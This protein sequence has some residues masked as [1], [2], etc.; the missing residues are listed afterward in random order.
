MEAKQMTK[1]RADFHVHYNVHDPEATKRIIDEA[2]GKNVVVLGLVGRLGMSDMLAEI[3]EYGKEK[4]VK[5]LPAVEYPALID[6]QAV[7]LLAIAFDYQNE[8]IKKLF[9]PLENRGRNAMI[10]QN[11]KVFLEGK[12]FLFDSL[13]DDEQQIL[14]R[15]LEGRID[16]KAIEFCKLVVK[17]KLNKV[18]LQLLKEEMREDWEFVK[19]KYGSNLPYKDDPQEFDAKFLWYLY[20]RPPH[21]EGFK[22]QGGG[23]AEL[24]LKPAAGI[25][26]TI[27]E[28]DGVV[29]Y[30]PEG[31]FDGKIWEHLK[32][33]G[34]DG[35]MAWH[36]DRMELDRSTVREIR[37]EGYLILGGSDYDPKKNEWGIG[38]GK[39]PFEMFIS[40][41]R[42]QEIEK[43]KQEKIL[44]ASKT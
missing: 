40:P 33:I 15:L 8:G 4:E 6:T 5:I 12:G 27:H 17:N 7:D 24:K 30:S 37:K 11:Q 29:L 32:I 20:F 21:G 43:Y 22:A 10:A 38:V 18:R 36:G 16:E 41:R 44:T 23:S 1:E 35:I 3:I 31:K 34:V 25:V 26:A 2:S 28:A 39:R 19:Q 13:Q 9:S 42:L 14:S